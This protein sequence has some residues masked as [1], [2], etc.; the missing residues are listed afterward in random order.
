[1]ADKK[2]SDLILLR[3]L[4]NLARRYWIGIA[5]IFVI[6]LLST[7]LALL[8][9]LPLKIV[10]DNVL[11]SR[12]LPDFVYAY[13][14]S[15]FTESAGRI[16]VL[17]V[18]LLL[19]AAL[20]TQLLQAS[21]S[22]LS[23]QGGQKLTLNFR[24]QL[25]RHVQRLSLRYHDSKSTAD[26]LYRIQYDTPSIQWVIID[27]LI[28]LASSCIMLVAMICVI[29]SINWQLALVA[30]VVSPVILIITAIHRPILKEQS[31]VVKRFESS[32]LQVVEEVLNALR[33]VKAFGQEDREEDRYIRRS[34][35]SVKA[36]ICLIW[37]QSRYEIMIGL[38]AACGTAAV[39]I[40]G[41]RLI[42]SNSMTLGDLLLVMGYLTQLYGPLS[43]IGRTSV[44]LQ[45]SLASAERAFTIL[46]HEPDVPEIPDARRLI[47]ASGD[48]NFQNISF[49][50]D[51]D[52]PVL[53]N[54][55]FVVPKGT[56]VGISGTTGAGKTTLT[57]LLTRF[58]D[59]TE[60]EI[61][62]DG[63]NL[64]NY[65][66]TDLRNQFAIVLQE[67]VLFSTTIAEN[68]A[69]A[70]PGASQE[71]IIAAARAANAHDFISALPDGYNTMVGER[72]M[73]LSG[74]ERQ[75]I[76]LARAFLKDAPILILD[77]PTSSV[78]MATEALIMKAME[79]LTKGRTSFL[80]T[81][82]TSTLSYCDLLITIENGLISQDSLA[83]SNS[84]TGVNPEISRRA[85]ND[86]Q[87]K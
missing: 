44:S 46:D 30:L 16:L 54:I 39:L 68:I 29:A 74:G 26:S 80:I 12:P 15:V 28:P 48:I 8:T 14:P 71:K 3:R 55:S 2:Y 37:I 53:N 58:Y 86:E 32:A 10:V 64:K 24:A 1:M 47:R 4:W 84:A 83:L 76:S 65:K 43:N 25:F 20:F 17:A 81:H 77:E 51:P 23:T 38:T 9:P 59:P 33:V 22:I 11:G 34:T 82:R 69:Y 21:S 36:N 66:V 18:I 5:A 57:N 73:R 85:I 40:L 49:A 56:R 63:V 78:D 50:Y 6:G 75:R 67:P 52:H 41:V 61:F 60:G 87:Q 19:I 31:H 45:A 35:D 79:R 70:D 7:P 72:G 42:Q 13:L 62:L 27:A